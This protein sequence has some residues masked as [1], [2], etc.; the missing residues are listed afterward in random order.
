MAAA[1]STTACTDEHHCE[2]VYV[3]PYLTVQVDPYADSRSPIATRPMSAQ[4]PWRPV[5]GRPAPTGAKGVPK[6][7]LI[8]AFPHLSAGAVGGL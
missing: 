6:S 8:G 3:H 5:K 1:G 7:G 2:A 4:G